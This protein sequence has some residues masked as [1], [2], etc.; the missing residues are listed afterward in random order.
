MVRKIN[1][2]Y[3]LNRTEA[4][5]YLTHAYHLKWCMTRWEN[6]IIRIT[7][8]KSDGLRG[9]AK[10][11]AYKCAKSKIVRLRKLDL[12]NYFTSN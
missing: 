6:R 5:E 9:N 3:F 1:E 4:I 11:E 2:E 8:A 7:F 12:D 10:F